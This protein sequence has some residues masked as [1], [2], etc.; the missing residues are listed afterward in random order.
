MN[1]GIGVSSAILKKFLRQPVDEL[2]LMRTPRLPAVGWT[3]SPAHLNGLVRLGERRI[4][5]SARV[6]S[7]S[8]RA[9]V[10]SGSGLRKFQTSCFLLNRV[11]DGRLLPLLRQFILIQNRNNK[12]M[13][14]SEF[15]HPPALINSVGIWL[16]AGDLWHFSFLIASSSSKALE[17]VRY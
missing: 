5:V 10:T 7:G 3:D 15:F 13:D 12:F 4:V 11:Y 6:P 1:E 16:T 2:T 17:S 14:H 8:A 9:P